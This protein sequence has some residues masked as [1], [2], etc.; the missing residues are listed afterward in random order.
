MSAILFTI[1]TSSGCAVAPISSSELAKQSRDILLEQ[2]KNGNRSV[3]LAIIDLTGG[4]A[5]EEAI[6]LWE[7]GLKDPDQSIVKKTLEKLVEFKNPMAIPEKKKELADR[8]NADIIETLIELGAKDLDS[9]IELGLTST[10]P[11]NRARAVELL[12]KYKGKD[13]EDRLRAF[14]KD[15]APIVGL[16]AKAGLAK[17]GD[18]EVLKGLEVYLNSGDEVAQLAAINLIRDYDLKEYRDKLVE[19][20]KIREGLVAQEAMRVLYKWDDPEGREMMKYEISNA[21]GLLEYPL[22]KDIEEKKDKEMVSALRSA[23]ASSTPN[24]RYSAGRVAVAVDPENTKDVLE[25]LLKGLTVEDPGVREQIA[26]SFSKLP[27]FPTVK[28]ALETKGIKDKDLKTRKASIIALG[29][30]GDHDSLKYLA[31]ILKSDNPEMKVAAAAAIV[32]IIN[33]EGL[34]GKIQK[35]GKDKTKTDMPKEQDKTETE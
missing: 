15:D 35:K 7:L 2:M 34:P 9:N 6:P 8:F 20:A 5:E 27:G 30:V 22:L 19:L 21:I 24:E 23:M 14:L 31:P 29:K 26:I 16:K 18:T 3:R 12:A 33:R 13:A 28:K 4:M 25:F 32:N 10:N 17:L 1:A 11:T